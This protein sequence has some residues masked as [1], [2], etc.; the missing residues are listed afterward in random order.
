MQ[1]RFLLWLLV[2]GALPAWGAAPPRSSSCARASATLSRVAVMGASVSAGFG[3]GRQEGR[4]R[5]LAD[6]LDDTVATEHAPVRNF[7]SLWFFKNPRSAGQRQ[8]DQVLTYAPTLTVAVD[9]LFWFVHG[10]QLDE[11][12]RLARLEQGLALLEPLPGPILLGELPAMTTAVGKAL[13]P[14]MLPSPETLA[15][16]NRRISEWARSRDNVVLLPLGTWLVRSPD[17]SLQADGL[18]PTR[19][20]AKWIAARMMDSLFEACPAPGV[21]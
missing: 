11:A 14:G 21:H 16:L 5:T 17:G 3:W 15:R 7:A 4:G 2:V 13:E 10:A 6:L 9:F 20:G 12:Q 19:E 18:H 8:V 1:M